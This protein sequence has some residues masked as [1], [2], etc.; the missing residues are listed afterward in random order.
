M[1]NDLIRNKVEKICRIFL[2]FYFFFLIIQKEESFLNLNKNKGKI[3]YKIAFKK[4]DRQ[5]I[6][7]IWIIPPSYKQKSI[8]EIYVE[9]KF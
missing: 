2:L 9:Y 6:N 1:S 5:N 8:F 7:P 3:K 4:I